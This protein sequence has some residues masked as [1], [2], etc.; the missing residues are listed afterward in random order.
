MKQSSPLAAVTT[1]LALAA[2]G[3]TSLSTPMADP[4][5]A[6]SMNRQVD[7]KGGAGVGRLVLADGTSLDKWECKYDMV[8]VERIQGRPKTESGLFVPRENLPKLH[9]CRGELLN[10]NFYS[11]RKPSSQN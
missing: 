2:S 9:L 5:A 1:I 11:H 3:V 7:F 6:R 4:S 8:L 10:V